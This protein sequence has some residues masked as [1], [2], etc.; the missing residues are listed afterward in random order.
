MTKDQFIS[1]AGWQNITFGHAT[2]LSKMAHLVEEVQE[3]VTALQNNDQSKRIEFA[4]CFILL[5]GAAASDGMSYD[6][7]CLAIDEKMSINYKRSWGKIE[8]NGVV[9]HTKEGSKP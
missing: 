8:E 1:I 5:F 9:H 4:D 6:D 2:A 7:I 3:L